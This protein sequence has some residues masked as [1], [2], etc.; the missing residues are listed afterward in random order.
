MECPPGEFAVA[1]RNVPL[2]IAIG[3]FPNYMTQS[4]QTAVDVT[5]I[6]GKMLACDLLFVV[7]SVKR[8]RV[9]TRE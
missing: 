8:Q 2:D 4:Q 1:V 5:L 9:T 6:M 7:L 3:E